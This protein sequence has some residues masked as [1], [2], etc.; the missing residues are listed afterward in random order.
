[1]NT[2]TALILLPTTEIVAAIYDSKRS[3][4]DKSAVARRDELL[5]RSHGLE[6]VIGESSQRVA[7]D[8]LNEVD[9]M[10]KCAEKNRTDVKSPFFTICKRIDEAAKTFCNPLDKE[11]QRLKNAIGA[12]QAEQ[13]R[14]AQEAERKQ[15][16]ELA[17]LNQERL[18]AEAAAQLAKTAAEAEKAQEQILA[19][20]TKAAEIVMTAPVVAPV[21]PDTIKV[22]QSWKVTVIDPYALCK[23]FPEML[24]LT[25]KMREIQAAVNKMAE[26]DPNT[27]PKLPGC[28]IEKHT[29][30][31][32]K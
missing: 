21:R 17:R 20:D 18:A 5:E 31:M 32:S 28:I 25:P 16:E 12:Y 29:E 14:K 22:K 9:G 10:L 4:L 8:L 27:A 24:T 1:M 7:A 6:R 30:V 3:L 11:K 26:S 23:V 13:I 19:A 2:N 15:Q